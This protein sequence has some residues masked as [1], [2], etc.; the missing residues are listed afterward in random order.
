MGHPNK[1]HVC[2]KGKCLQQH[3]CRLVGL[4]WWEDHPRDKSA[5]S[6]GQT[7]GTKNGRPVGHQ[8]A[9]C[10][11][12]RAKMLPTHRQAF[13]APIQLA[14]VLLGPLPFDF[15]NNLRV[16]TEDHQSGF[17]EILTECVKWKYDHRTH[18]KVLFPARHLRRTISLWCHHKDLWPML[19]FL[20]EET[21]LYQDKDLP[22]PMHEGHTPS[23]SEWMN[24]TKE[25]MQCELFLEPQVLMVTPE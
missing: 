20:C 19:F 9:D 13:W 15:Q 4:L 11:P 16:S 14:D 17:L 25:T 10:G 6:K 22:K 23:C 8:S 5:A 18:P 1:P 21:A 24:R 12:L 3:S 2:T 7:M